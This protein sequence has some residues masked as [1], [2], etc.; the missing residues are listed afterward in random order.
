M[1][2]TSCTL[3]FRHL[4]KFEWRLGVVTKRTYK[5]IDKKCVVANEQ[6]P[7][8]TV[9]EQPEEGKSFSD[10]D[11]YG[12]KAMTDVVIHGYVYTPGVETTSLIASV[13]IEDIVRN[14]RVYGN[15]QIQDVNGYYP[16]FSSPVPFSQMPLTYER[17]YGGFDEH[18]ARIL[19]DPVAEYAVKYG[20]V[21]F[22][23]ASNFTYPRNA[24]GKGF[25]I[26]LD[27][28][29][30][31][32]TAVPNLEDP[33]DPILPERIFCERWENWIDSP[34]PGALDWMLPSDFP[35]CVHFNLL[36]DYLPAKRPIRE[37]TLG[38]L[39]TEDMQPRELLELPRAYAANGAA[40]GLAKK[41]LKGNE[42]VRLVHLHYKFRE[43]IFQLP[44]EQPRL[45]IQPP[46]CPKMELEPLLDTIY[47]EPSYDRVSLVW[48]GSLSVACR[49]PEH[50]FAQVGHEVVW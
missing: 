9:D 33:E 8:M 45:K 47:I 21:D 30:V 26:A 40:P 34:I 13:Q 23:E 15:R 5:V 48:S 27:P 49:Y 39:K 19:G 24:R 32:G 46:G 28:E 36:P 3:N 31:I 37:I 43:L 11:A 17:S 22:A 2:S 35:R 29:R 14:V 18:A 25:F 12:F 50:E 38:A 44:G 1:T 41:R 4:P 10:K 7:L 6:L 42:V 16:Y 20:K